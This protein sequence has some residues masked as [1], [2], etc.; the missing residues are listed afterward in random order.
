[1][2]L[3]QTIKND[4]LDFR[5]EGTNKVAI[6]L[7]TTL[8]GE[9]SMSGFNDGKRESTDAEVIAVIK[10]FVK[11]LNEVIER[12]EAL[13]VNCN[14]QHQEL[15]IL[16]LYLPKQLSEVELK[17]IIGLY[18]DKGIN[19][20]GSIMKALKDQYNGQY[21]GKLASNIISLEVS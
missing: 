3:L 20:K 1:M 5:K 12:A 9:A 11:G 16:D 10:K 19:T 14:N 2:S 13:N 7:L 17:T 4:L 21:D 18:I 8:V 6:A 15:S